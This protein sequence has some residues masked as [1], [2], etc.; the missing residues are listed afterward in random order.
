[1]GNPFQFF[2]RFVLGQ[3]LQIKGQ[4]DIFAYRQRIEKVVFL[5]YEAK[6]IPPKG[7]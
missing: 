1:L 7:G 3:T 6:L 5:K 2:N 4:N